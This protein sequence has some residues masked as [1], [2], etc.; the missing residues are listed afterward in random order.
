MKKESTRYKIWFLGVVLE[1]VIPVANAIIL[2]KFVSALHVTHGHSIL[3]TPQS[4]A[5]FISLM[6]GL[7]FQMLAWRHATFV[8]D[9]VVICVNVLAHVALIALYVCYLDVM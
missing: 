3:S 6:L 1:S 7:L 4:F 9:R 8:V 2:A 5:I